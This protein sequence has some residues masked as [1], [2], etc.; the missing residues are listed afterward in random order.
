METFT[1]CSL[2]VCVCRRVDISGGRV[3]AHALSLVFMVEC[4][5]PGIVHG[6]EEMLYM[7]AYAWRYEQISCKSLKKGV[8]GSPLNS[9]LSLF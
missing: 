8:F 9:Q 2:Y 1:S 5:V 6:A 4:P 3:R 7:F